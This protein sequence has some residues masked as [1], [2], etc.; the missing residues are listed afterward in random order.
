VRLPVPGYLPALALP[1]L[2][3]T[4]RLCTTV[5]ARY[6]ASLEDLWD[7]A[8]SALIRAA[9]YYDPAGG[10]FGRYGRTA[11]HRALARAVHVG[12]KRGPRAGNQP[13]LPRHQ[14]PLEDVLPG[15][16]TSPSAEAEAIAR[17]TVRR[18]VLLREHAVIA[19]ARG[20]DDTT[21]RLCAAAS[22]A[23][24]VARRPRRHSPPSSR[25]TLTMHRSSVGA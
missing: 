12:Q 1:V 13:R 23:D 25:S 22:A 24:R 16:L 8:V 3:F 7:D 11:V 9:V 10:P 2:P 21:S 17:D 19:A 4:R 6:Q 5:A 15:E 14:V 18:A 20:D